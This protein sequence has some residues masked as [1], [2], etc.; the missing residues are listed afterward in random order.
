M[1]VNELR[2]GNWVL[3]DWENVYEKVT[4]NTLCFISLSEKI[5]EKHPFKQIPL[6]E[7]I[8]LKCGFDFSETDKSSVYK[9]GVF[10]T[11]FVK[12]GKF[13]G[14]KYLIIYNN[15]SFENFGHIQ[16]LHQ[17]QNLYYALTNQE[18]GVEL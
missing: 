6:T 2:I 15:I 4:L 18:L 10:R 5:G 3:L 14:K 8:L 16:Y 11:N 1:K 9:L 17:L 7:E 12:D 13:K